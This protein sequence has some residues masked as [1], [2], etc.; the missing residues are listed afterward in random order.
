[1]KSHVREAYS[2]YKTAARPPQSDTA[3]KKINT[4]KKAKAAIFASGNSRQ[5]CVHA[6]MKIIFRDGDGSR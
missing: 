2:P 4:G 3:L 1:M 6:E 5:A